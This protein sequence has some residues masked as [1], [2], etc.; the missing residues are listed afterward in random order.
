MP[1]KIRLDNPVLAYQL[2]TPSGEPWGSPMRDGD[3]VLATI[4]PRVEQV[5]KNIGMRLTLRWVYV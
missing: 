5:L 2:V 1:I 4:T 3:A